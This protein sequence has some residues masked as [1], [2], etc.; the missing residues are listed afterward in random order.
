V[1]HATDECLDVVGLVEGGDDHRDTH[2]AAGY[3]LA[4][5]TR[6]LSLAAAGDGTPRP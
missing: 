6:M 5:V 4:P 3:L 2:D 1:A